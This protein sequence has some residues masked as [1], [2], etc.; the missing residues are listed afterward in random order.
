MK[1]SLVN[2]LIKYQDIQE[3]IF[4]VSHLTPYSNWADRCLYGTKKYDSHKH[5]NHR[6]VL[7][8]EV[9]FEYDYKDDEKNR[10]LVMT[11]NKRLKELGLSTSM[12]FSGGKSYHLHTFINIPP[13]VEPREWKKTFIYF[14]CKGLPNPDLLVVG[15]NHLIRAEYGLHEKTRRTKK[16]CNESKDYPFV[17]DVSDLIMEQYLSYKKYISELPKV[18]NDLIHTDD[19]KFLMNTQEF[20]KYKDGVQRGL[21]ILTHVLKENMNKEEVKT[22]LEKWYKEVGG[23]KTDIGRHVDYQWEKNYPVIGH[24]RNLVSDLKHN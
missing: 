6:A 1:K 16:L 19:V 2:Y 9:V 22:Y 18:T 20:R 24:L 21:F 15:D 13:N 23:Y 11:V 10:E 4:L 5:Y 17:K 3:Y 8:N 12:W 7:R 14:V